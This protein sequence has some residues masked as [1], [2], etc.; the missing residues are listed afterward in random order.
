VKVKQGTKGESERK[1]RVKCART[2]GQ[3]LHGTKTSDG[4]EKKEEKRM[5]EGGYISRRRSV[6]MDVGGGQTGNG[7]PY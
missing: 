5:Q 7:N 6:G 1:M 4:G 3:K 2:Q